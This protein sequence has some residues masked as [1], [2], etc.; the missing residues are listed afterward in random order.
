MEYGLDGHTLVSRLIQEVMIM[1]IEKI[2]QIFADTAYVRTSTSPEELKCAE[3]IKEQCAQMGLEAHLESF[4]IERSTIKKAVLLADGKEIPCAGYMC[5]GSAEIEAPFYYLSNRDAYSLKNCSGKIVMID[6]AGMPRWTYQDLL[7]NGAVGYITYCGDALYADED[8]ARKELRPYVHNGIKIPGINI[9]AKSAIELVR[10]ETKTVKIILEQDEYMGTSHN[11]VL[12]LPGEIE[13]TI[14]LSAHYDSTSLSVGTYDNM[15][16][17]VGLLGIAE[18]FAKEPHRYSLRFIWCGSEEI[19]LMG[20]RAYTK[21]HLSELEHFVLNVNLDMIGS[22]MGKFI[23]CCSADEKLVHF[24][25]YLGAIEGFGIAAKQDVYAS[26]STPFADAGVPSLSFA[27][28][29]PH[30]TAT[31]HTRYDTIDVM[32]AEQMLKDIAFI[33]TFVDKM[34]NAK[35]CPVSRQIP[36]AVKEKLDVYLARKRGNNQ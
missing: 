15:S 11:V 19:G 12:D 27:R 36:D 10:N 6:A 7:D 33:N 34:A 18:K 9:N 31:I 16:G 26:D 1:N 5:S 8:I 20:S 35:L 32:K 23:A 14:V 29:A 24:I 3:Y 25:E 22:I 21:A 2:N 17:C 28:L 4:E 13:D 30:N